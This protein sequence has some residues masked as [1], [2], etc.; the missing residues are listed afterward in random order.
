M[1]TF[2][3]R[4]AHSLA[5]RILTDTVQSRS[6]SPVPSPP[7]RIFLSSRNSAHLSSFNPAALPIVSYLY[8]IKSSFAQTVDFT[9]NIPRRNAVDPPRFLAAGDF[10]GGFILFLVGGE[11]AG[12]KT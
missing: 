4:A 6:F 12:E 7:R 11:Q 8:K 1:A 5:K 3:E 10:R 2:W 9:C